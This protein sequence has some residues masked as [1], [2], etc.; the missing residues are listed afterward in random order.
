MLRALIPARPPRWTRVIGYTLMAAGGVAAVF[1]PT[2]S[3][4]LAAGALVYLWAAFLAVGGT[5]A[6]VGAITD[7]WLGEH[8]GLPLIS[9]AWAVYAVVLALGGNPASRAA[10]F[11][12]AA[13]AFLLWGRRRDVELI[14]REATRRARTEAQ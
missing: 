6:A 14:R 7:R 12:F 3:V 5:L 11:A 10:A 4:R 2:P 1:V 9:A 13:V 8:L